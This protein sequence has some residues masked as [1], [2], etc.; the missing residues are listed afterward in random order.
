VVTRKRARPGKA[1]SGHPDI[2][3]LFDADGASDGTNRKDLL[4]PWS[5]DIT[6]QLEVNIADE[7]ALAE[8]SRP[9]DP[10]VESDCGWR[11]NPTAV[12]GYEA[13]LRTLRSALEAAEGER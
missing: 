7:L 1:Q 8:S 13:R 12:K 10:V 4:M 5:D 2:T 9:D 3:N 6:R 11:P